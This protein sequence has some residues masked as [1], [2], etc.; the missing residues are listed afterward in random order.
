[1]DLCG[2]QKSHL[3]QMRRGRTWMILLVRYPGL[4]I[5]PCSECFDEMS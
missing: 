3:T 1:M 5:K 4:A 2:G